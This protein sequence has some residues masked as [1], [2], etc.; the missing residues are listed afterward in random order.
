[1]RGMFAPHI[2]NCSLSG[3]GRRW[4]TISWCVNPCLWVTAG[5]AQPWAFLE[6]GKALDGSSWAWLLP[7][8]WG[9][10]AGQGAAHGPR[11]LHFLQDIP[12]LSF[13]VISLYQSFSQFY[14]L[15]QI[16]HRS[17]FQT[18]FMVKSCNK[19]HSAVSL[20][21]QSTRAFCAKVPVALPAEGTLESEGRAEP[22]P[23]LFPWAASA[24]G[25]HTH[26]VP[27]C[28]SVSF[29]RPASHPGRWFSHFLCLCLS[30]APTHARG[31]RKFQ[32]W[33]IRILE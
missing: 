32:P 20:Q 25:G 31:K 2:L 33:R 19:G 14:Q 4:V 15:Y 1:M 18:D 30:I 28:P 7:S 16:Q 6:Q 11:F 24:H 13:S 22:P 5:A 17:R 12:R 23:A 27:L 10:R 3:A 8:H 26:I 21:L 9:T 29:C